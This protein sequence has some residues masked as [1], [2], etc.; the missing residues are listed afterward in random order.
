MFLSN[1]S[2]HPYGSV[3]RKKKCWLGQKQDSLLGCVNAFVFFVNTNIPGFT[4][5]C[6]RE[7]VQD[8]LQGVPKNVLC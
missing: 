1:C 8:L 2:R 6:G 5:L 4:S 3:W 7:K